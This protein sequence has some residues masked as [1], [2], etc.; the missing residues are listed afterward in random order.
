MGYNNLYRLVGKIGSYC[1]K[2]DVS[3]NRSCG[4]HLHVSNK[5]FSSQINLKKIVNTW[6]AIEDVLFS[7][8]PA[9]RLTNT[10]CHRVLGKFV[11]NALPELPR[12]KADLIASQRNIDRYTALNFNALHRHGTL[13]VRLHA[14]TTNK[15]K[16]RSWM[17]L[18]RG[19]FNYCLMDYNSDDVAELMNLTINEEKVEKALKLFKLSRQTTEFYNSRIRTNLFQVLKRQ[20]EAANN[21]K[22]LKPQL[23]RKTK[24]LQRVV[25]EHEDLDA[26]ARGF[27]TAFR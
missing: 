26:T 6:L 17:E 12:K 18:V 24:Q 2:Y 1:E 3:V 22:K 21:Y 20:Q 23:D 14:G 19:F 27:R 15:L 4:L 5:R 16:I 10:Y 8:Q 7:T 9:S 25:R 13:E 11:N